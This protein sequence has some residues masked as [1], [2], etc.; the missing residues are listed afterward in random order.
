MLEMMIT[1]SVLILI[2]LLLRKITRGRISMRFRYALWLAVVLRLILPVS[3]GN[4]A[5]S[6]MNILPQSR[7]ENENTGRDVLPPADASALVA[8]GNMTEAADN[9]F[10]MTQVREKQEAGAD[11][12]SGAF[13]DSGRE[14]GE[15]GVLPLGVSDQKQDAGNPE[16]GADTDRM[17]RMLWSIWLLGA[18][19]VGGYMAAGQVRFVR[20]LH[21]C[22]RIVSQEKLPRILT[23]RLTKRRMKVYQVKGLA[24]PCLVGRNIYIDAGLAEDKQKLV[25]IL[26]HEYCH[27]VQKD[28]LWTFLRCALVT[29]YWFHPLVWAAAFGARQDSELSC[30]EAVIRL[31]GEKERFAYGRTLLYL[32][33]GRCGE[34]DCAGTA[35]TMEG[36]KRGIKERVRMI[37]G[38]SD[39]KRWMAAMVLLT[40]LLACGCA[41]TGSDREA[42]ALQVQDGGKAQQEEGIQKTVQDRRQMVEEGSEEEFERIRKEYEEAVGAVDAQEK[43]LE[44]LEQERAFQ[45]ALNYQGV[46]AGKDDSELFLD[47]EIDY[48]AY[49]EYLYGMQADDQEEKPDNP[50]ENGWYL[51]CRSEEAGISLYGLYTEEFG[52]RGVKTLIGEDVN[53]YDISWCGSRMNGY[54]ANIRVLETAE[55]GFPARFVFKLLSENTAEREIWNLYSGLRYDTGTVQLEELTAQMYREWAEKNLS[56]TVSDS[57]D[58]VLIT[59]EGDMVLAPL[60]ISAYHDQKIEKAMINFDVAGFDLASSLYEEGTYEGYEGV[61]LQLAVGLKLEGQSEVWF[62]GLRPLSV[63]VLCHQG[64]GEAFVLQ[65]PRIDESSQLNALP[66]RRKLEEIRTGEGMD[67]QDAD[68]EDSLSEPLVNSG[69]N[70]YDLTITFMNPCPDYDRISDWYGERTNPATGEIRKHNGVDMAAKQGTAVVAAAD[71]RVYETGYDAVNGN[72]VVLWH[73]QSGQMT[74]YMHC[75]EIL[76]TEKEKVKAGDKIATVGSTGKSTGYHLHFAVSS[77]R[78]WEEP[79]WG[80]GQLEEE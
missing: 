53:S 10:K 48:Q 17:Q 56:F 22:R 23:D 79:I 29:V 28:T 67:T 16:S 47:R 54:S 5:L 13:A 2:I 80:K 74:Y 36:R 6:V 19:A 20:I 70:H 61:V 64:Q 75:E 18:M 49:Y 65:Q 63:Q 45:E 11:K 37:A 14:N 15:T 34:V 69:D 50:L 51:I 38:K 9:I 3:V 59:Y 57:K 25:H 43:T 76:V 30:D 40:M 21:R 55:D 44:T 27:A 52:F 26:A 46:M 7:Q 12:D 31:L 78:E 73:G 1:S 71:G 35:L 58:E 4:S 8:A 32:L 62:D 24:S 33:S 66:Q 77:G 72:Y 60:D 39:R 42:D 68:M 41:F